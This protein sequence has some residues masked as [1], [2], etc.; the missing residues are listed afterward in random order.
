MNVPSLVSV[1][2]DIKFD[3]SLLYKIWGVKSRVFLYMA[4]VCHRPVVRHVHWLPHIGFLSLHQTQSVYS[5][6]NAHVME[7]VQWQPLPI[8]KLTA[9]QWWHGTGLKQACRFKI[10][11]M[12]CIWPYQVLFVS[13]NSTRKS[14]SSVSSCL[15]LP[16]SK[17]SVGGTGMGMPLW[18]IPSRGMLG[19]TICWKPSLV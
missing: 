8:C 7:L 16:R 9:K 14:F 4:Q 3:R 10:Y 1:S 15:R 17:T 6:V 5:V 19:S 13:K 18:R 2:L 12:K 11:F